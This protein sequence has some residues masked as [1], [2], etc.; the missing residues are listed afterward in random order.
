MGSKQMSRMIQSAFGRRYNLDHLQVSSGS[1]YFISKLRSAFYMIQHRWVRYSST[2][3]LLIA[4]AGSIFYY[5][6][7]VTTEQDVLASRGKVNAL[8]QR[9]NDISINLSKAVLDYAKHERGVFTGVVALRSVLSKDAEKD[10]KLDEMFNRVKQQ[11]TRAGAVK[12]AKTPPVPG[13]WSPLARLLAVAEQYPDLKL[14]NTFINLMTAL[15]EIE[16]DL[17]SER[18]SYN[19]NV[20]IYTTNMAK[21]PINIYAVLL[22]FK[23]KPYFVATDEAQKLKPIAY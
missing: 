2:L 19:D 11:E 22:G 23:E 7:L 9:R 1:Q 20:N 21:F 14:S 16:K 18:I 17:A 12:T 15:I 10:P 4:A 13:A 5:N 8:L 6:L 3:I